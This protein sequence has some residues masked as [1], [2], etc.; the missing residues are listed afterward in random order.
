MVISNQ[1]LSKFYRELLTMKTLLGN[2]S[3]AISLSLYL[4]SYWQG[5]IIL[6][7]Q[8]IQTFSYVAISIYQR[9]TGNH[10]N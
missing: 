2:F 1:K 6:I 8:N 3:M 7:G 10:Q 4:F 5:Y 9:L